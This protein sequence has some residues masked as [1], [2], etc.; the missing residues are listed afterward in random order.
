M[1]FVLVVALAAACSDSAPMRPTASASRRL[2]HAA[3]R[4]LSESSY[5]LRM[6]QVDVKH[7]HVVVLRYEAPDRSSTSSSRLDSVAIGN[8][9]YLRGP[10]GSKLFTRS[11]IPVTSLGVAG[12]PSYATATAASLLYPAQHARRNVSMHGDTITATTPK[13]GEFGRA[14][15]I[16]RVSDGRIT[17]LRIE[18]RVQG[19]SFNRE[20]HYF[21]FG[22]PNVIKPPPADQVQVSGPSSSCA[23]GSVPSTTPPPTVQ[24]CG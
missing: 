13:H 22:V 20:Y 24:A 16:Y 11:T 6:G 5:K 18:Q 9:S 21:D 4:T 8:T 1:G 14:Q 2:R 19:K 15:Y 7:P 23:Q 12:Y 17:D 3:D 10:G